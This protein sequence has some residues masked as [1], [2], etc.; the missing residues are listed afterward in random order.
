VAGE[1]SRVS[2]RERLSQRGARARAG[3][4]GVRGGPPLAGARAA[5]GG[6]ARRA[7]GARRGVPRVEARARGR[8]VHAARLAARQLRRQRPDARRPRALLRAPARGCP[9]PP[10]GRALPRASPACRNRPDAARQLYLW[11]LLAPVHLSCDYSRNTVPN[12]LALHDQRNAAAAAAYT[13]LAAL[14]AAAAAAARRGARAAPLAEGLV[15]LAGPFALASNALFPV[16]TVLGERLLYLPSA[17]FCLL[18]AAL[19]QRLP[20]PAAHAVRPRAPA[21][22]RPRAPHPLCTA[23][24][25]RT[26]ARSDSP[27]RPPTPP[28][29][30]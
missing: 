12:V 28:P 8:R 1:Y 24:R 10:A 4:Q 13:A 18:A 21:P 2:G 14:A 11:K 25:P 27:P 5:R 3:A 26:G 23:L 30:Y 29:S 20:A 15:W 22:P 16:A 7:G 17:G 19:L 9:R 6:A